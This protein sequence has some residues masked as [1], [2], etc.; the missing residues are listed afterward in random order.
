MWS[1]VVSVLPSQF[2]SFWWMK[3]SSLQFNCCSNSYQIFWK[4]GV[5]FMWLIWYCSHHS[6]IQQNRNNDLCV[7][8]MDNSICKFKRHLDPFLAIYRHYFISYFA[9]DY[10][11]SLKL[12]ICIDS[13]DPFIYS[14]TQIMLIIYIQL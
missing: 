10:Y 3:F 14:Q 13:F 9:S 8:I 2:N 5:R 6:W 11:I 12:F 4:P 7:C 1:I